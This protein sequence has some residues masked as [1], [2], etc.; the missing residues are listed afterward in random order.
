MERLFAN[1][2]IDW[3]RLSG[4][5]AAALA[6]SSHN[7]EYVPPLEALCSDDLRSAAVLRSAYRGGVARGI[8]ADSEAAFLAFLSTAAYCTRVG[9][10]PAAL[11]VHLVKHGRLLASLKDEDTAD[12]A[13]KQLLATERE[14]GRWLKR[15][16]EAFTPKQGG[17][18]CS[19]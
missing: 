12:R 10:S 19:H 15:T 17:G 5:K 11:F 9:R 6:E 3:Q 18:V 1:L 13:M 14:A 4:P 7:R 8:L 2:V 16:T